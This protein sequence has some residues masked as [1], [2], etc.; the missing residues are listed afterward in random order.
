MPADEDAQHGAEEDAQHGVDE[1]AAHASTLARALKRAEAAGVLDEPLRAAA[2]AATRRLERLLRARRRAHAE[3]MA[4]FDAA[5]EVDAAGHRSV[6]A[7]AS[8]PSR[9]KSA[10]SQI[11]KSAEF[12]D[13][14][15]ECDAGAGASDE[16]RLRERFVNE[17]R[18]KERLSMA[19]QQARATALVAPVVTEAAARL[20]RL[21]LVAEARAADVA[22]REAAAAEAAALAQVTRLRERVLAAQR[23]ATLEA[24]ARAVKEAA[25]VEAAAREAARAAAQEHERM[26]RQRAAREARQQRARAEADVQR[27]AEVRARLQLRSA[28]SQSASLA[29]ERRNPG[30]SLTKLDEPRS[31]SLA[32][33]RGDVVHHV[34]G[35]TAQAR[36][37]EHTHDPNYTDYAQARHSH[38]ASAASAAAAAAAAAAALS[39]SLASLCA[40]VKVA[41]REPS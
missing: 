23:A 5:R 29:D 11:R 9:R 2:L 3:L 15:S 24:E 34:V 28:V 20:Q 37:Y 6:A 10:D 25:Q 18:L 21:E 16:D 12:E 39:L 30:R 27:Q 22:L 36:H 26:A 31:A 38:A 7:G 4:A 33:E 40:G 1:D 17:D 14:D 8:E 13:A 35:T 41:P 19:L 32:D